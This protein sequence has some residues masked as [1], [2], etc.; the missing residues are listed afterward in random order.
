MYKR[1]AKDRA[2]FW[3]P[4]LSLEIID[5]TG[6][7]SERLRGR[8]G[9]DQSVWMLFILIYAI[10]GM[11]GV[12]ALM[13]GTSQWLINESPWALLAVPACVALAAFVYGAA[14]IG[15]G[16]GA[17]QMYTLRSFVDDAIDAAR[18]ELSAGA[19]APVAHT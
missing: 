12:L 15:Q 13:F 3:S 10:L 9:P 1:Q 2:H 16:L 6:A 5:E 19:E 8:F 7:T 11:V 14:F 17:E 18:E 4:N